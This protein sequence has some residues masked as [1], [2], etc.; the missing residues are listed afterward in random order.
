MTRFI[1]T[2]FQLLFCALAFASAP[3][4]AATQLKGLIEVPST[5]E[6]TPEFAILF[7]G[8]QVYCSEDGFF[9]FPVESTLSSLSILVCEDISI[10]FSQKDDAQSSQT[11][12]GLMVDDATP[13]YFARLTGRTDGSVF[14]KKYALNEGMVP[15]DCIVILANPSMVEKTQRLDLDA[16]LGLVSG[17]K[18]R[19]SGNNEAVKLSSVRSLAKCTDL[20]RY[21]KNSKQKAEWTGSTKMTINA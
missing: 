11:I 12:N 4:H 13:Y 6:S 5:L 18:I 10:Q 3:L 14:W 1:F 2:R 21:F 19:F 9:S 8:Q 17:P 20:V 7:D 16:S 15:S